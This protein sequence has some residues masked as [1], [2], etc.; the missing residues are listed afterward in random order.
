MRVFIDCMVY[1]H[2]RNLEDLDLP[3][4]LRNDNV[5]V[6][7]PRITLRE[8][9]KHK[10]THSSSR[11][12]DRARRILQKIERWTTERG[13]VRPG[14]SA[15]FFP[16]TPSIDYARYGLNPEWSDDILIA[17]VLH[18]KKDHPEEEVILIIQDSGPKL[19]ATQL[20]IKVFALPQEYKLPPEPDPLEVENR[21]L[22]RALARLQNAL[23]QLLACF[24]G[25]EEPKTY[26]RF[27]LQ[28]PPES[29]GEEIKRTIDEF[30]HKLP[31][32]YPPEPRPPTKRQ[33]IYE[34]VD[35][36]KYIDPIP[37]EEY[38]RYNKG[39]DTFLADY[40]SYMRETWEA[41]AAAKRSIRFQ[42][43]IRNIGTAP[44][45]DV[46]VEFH[47][48]DGF[49]LFTEDDWPDL[50]KEPRPPRK[51]MTRMQIMTDSIGRI[52]NFSFPSPSAPHFT[53]QTS[54]TIK[55][56]NS[57][58]VTDHFARI[59]HGAQVTV[60]ELFLA[61]DSYESASSFNCDYTIRPANLPDPIT[62][63][64]HFVIEKRNDSKT[65]SSRP[66]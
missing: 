54:F 65:D 4:M 17:S 16:A 26:A 8:L 46:D 50:P 21:E 11:I 56:T 40:E 14:M 27:F 18:Y 6:V 36:L 31:K 34:F 51:P 29:M 49:Q 47:F 24:A 25:S 1:L 30:R 57:Y 43:E 37:S 44:A 64:L 22:S 2:Y 38:E 45:D 33:T 28:T 66:E 61:F 63:Q 48:P 32:Q 23:P 55:R 7:V 20:G 42:I 59:K 9:D 35:S 5:F 19:T 10:N 12:R 52:P 58:D 53:I 41:K 13:N 62:G 15:E 60:P 39:V 3:S